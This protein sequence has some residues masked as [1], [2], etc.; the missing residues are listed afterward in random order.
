MPSEAA[1][2]FRDSAR[3]CPLPQGDNGERIFELHPGTA[4]EAALDLRKGLKRAL[5]LC[6]IPGFSPPKDLRNALPRPPEVAR[7]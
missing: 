1:F 5:P 7:A 6:I 3:P 2:R 4:G